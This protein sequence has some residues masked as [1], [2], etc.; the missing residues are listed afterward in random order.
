MST[1]FDLNANASMLNT[2]DLQAK[3]DAQSV[4]LSPS[5]LS[6]I[7]A[8]GFSKG[9]IHVFDGFH[10]EASVFFNNNRLVDKTKVTCIKWLPGSLNLFLAG[11]ASGCLYL[12]DATHQA[13][14]SVPPV[15]TKL[16]QDD[17]FAVHLNPNSAA[18]ANIPAERLDAASAKAGKLVLS[19]SNQVQ[20]AVARNPL[21]K[22]CVGAAETTG[23]D[24]LSSFTNVNSAGVNGVNDVQFSPCGSYLAVVSQ[25]GFLRLFAFAYQSN[26]HLQVQLLG[27]MKSYFGGLLCCAWSPDGRYVATGGEDDLVTVF[28]FVEMRVACR[29]RGHNSWINACVFDAWTDLDCGG[30]ARRARSRAKAES[31]RP[32]NKRAQVSSSVLFRDPAPRYG[33]PLKKK[34]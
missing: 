15:Y 27:S 26:Q 29:G 19:L 2:V 14:P 17:S 22:W 30:E 34:H 20:A 18:S 21:L 6:L 28:S 25:D 12:Y 32:A 4:D 11:H 24:G 16:Y 5:S 10:K 9:E 33:Q 23:H 1:C 31:G 8:A 3:S 13:Q 7:V